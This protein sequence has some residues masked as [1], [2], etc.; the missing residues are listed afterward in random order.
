M[1]KSWPVNFGPIYILAMLEMMGTVTD[2]FGT[3]DHW[4]EACR[5]CTTQLQGHLL[6]WTVLEIA[7]SGVVIHDSPGTRLHIFWKFLPIELTPRGQSWVHC[8]ALATCTSPASKCWPIREG[9][10]RTRNSLVSVHH[11]DRDMRN[12]VGWT[13]IA[14]LRTR[15]E[16]LK[17]GED[18]ECSEPEYLPG[19]LR[20]F[21]RHG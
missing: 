18:Y 16:V 7:P 4:G 2:S 15:K 10:G 14:A 3:R 1:E 21:E 12:L 6:M 11:R 5:L 9:M 8:S 20:S 19:S 13:L 17:W